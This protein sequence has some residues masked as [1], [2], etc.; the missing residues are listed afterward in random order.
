LAVKHFI[1]IDSIAIA[2]IMDKN[3]TAIDAFIELAV[4]NYQ[5]ISPATPTFIMQKSQKAVQKFADLVLH[6]FSTIHPMVICCMLEEN[7][8]TETLQKITELALQ[9]FTATYTGIF[10]V[11]MKKNPAV[12]TTFKDKALRCWQDLPAKTLAFCIEQEFFDQKLIAKIKVKLEN[13]LRNEELRRNDPIAFWE[14]LGFYKRTFDSTF[15]LACEDL[16]ITEQHIR[17]IDAL[18]CLDLFT[19]NPRMRAMAKEIIDQ[20]RAAANNGSY[21]FVHGQRWEYL[22]PEMLHTDLQAYH[23]GKPTNGF[24]YLHVRNQERP[25]KE[26]KIYKQLMQGGR[27]EKSDPK[28]QFLLFLNGPLFGNTGDDGSSTENYFTLN[29]NVG[30]VEVPLKSVFD[31]HGDGSIYEKYASELE[32]LKKEYDSLSNGHGNIFVI[33]IPKKLA[34]DYVYLAKP[35]GYKKTLTINGKETD[36]IHSVLSTL[37]NHPEEASEV[38]LNEYCLVMVKDAMNPE[39]GIKM[40]AFNVADPDKM[41]AFWKKYENLMTKV[42]AD[43]EAQQAG[44]VVPPQQQDGTVFERYQELFA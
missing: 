32:T 10:R 43:I 3:P 17:H 44:K 15:S 19:T 21:T 24:I 38:D 9:N 37:T 39:S 2:C 28:R 13:D 4:Q 40:K 18:Q 16:T 33:T 7:N 35:G 12:T 5:A 6:N 29:E 26:D 20:E 31:L 23:T 30:S 22:F 8:N 34:K 25:S 1:T 14:K 41:A 11:I 36:D 27:G 42:K